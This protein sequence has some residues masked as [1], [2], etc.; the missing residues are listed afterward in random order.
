[1][2]DDKPTTGTTL[3]AAHAPLV[4]LLILAVIALGGS[5]VTGTIHDVMKPK[6]AAPNDPITIP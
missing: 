6:V 4:I 2:V 3:T 5:V 1:M